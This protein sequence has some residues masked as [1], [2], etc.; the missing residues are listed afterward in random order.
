MKKWIT[1]CI[2]AMLV[3]QCLVPCA[4]TVYGTEEEI[5]NSV[6]IA[7]LSKLSVLESAGLT[8]SNEHT[9]NGEFSMKW[10]GNMS[11]T[12]I[13]IP[14]AVHDFSKYQYMEFAL[15]SSYR[16]N[17]EFMIELVSDNPDTP[18]T[19]GYSVKVT[20]DFSGRKTYSF[21][22][23]DGFVTAGSPIGWNQIDEMYFVP[24]N[25]GSADL[26]FE[27]I[28]L[29]KISHLSEE[30]EEIFMILDSGDESTY[31]SLGL[32]LTDKVYKHSDVSLTWSGNN[33]IT[34]IAF[35][36]IPSDWS[37]YKNL[38]M[39]LYV[40]T[41]SSNPLKP[42]IL[43]E[44]DTTTGADYYYT[45]V[46][47]AS[48]GW[49]TSVL[50][51]ESFT[52]SRSPV[53]W[54]NITGM[55]F[56]NTLGQTFDTST[57]LYIDRIYL[58]NRDV[59]PAEVQED[60]IVA[61]ENQKDDTDMVAM[62]KQNYPNQSHPRL[63]FDKEQLNTMKELAQY[64]AFA[65]NT[66][67]VVVAQANS[68]LDAPLEKYTNP[69]SLERVTINRVPTWAMAYLY[70]GD[71]KY[72][73]RVWAD[74][75]NICRYIDWNYG[76]SL[77][78]GD[79]ARAVA[80]MYDWLYDDWTEEQ[81]RV[82]RNALVRNAFA[83]AL[84]YMRT[85][86]GFVTQ[87]N[88]WNE[89]IN[90]GLGMAA[91]A[92]ADE[93][94]Y[95]DLCNE[96]LNRTVNALPTGLASF[97][98][99]GLSPEGVAYWTYAIYTFSQYD[100]SLFMTLG[101]DFGLSDMEGLERTGYFP[102]AAMS[103]AGNVFDFGDAEISSSKD[104]C[105][106][107]LAERYNKPELA[108]YVLDQKKYGGAFDLALYR[109]IPEGV[110]FSESM[111]LDN[112]FRGDQ[113][114]VSLRSSWDNRNALFVAFKG[115]ANYAGHNDLDQGDLVLDAMGV[116]WFRELGKED[117]NFP[118][119]WDMGPTG[120]RWQYYRKNAEG[121]NTIVIN[122]DDQ[123]M[124]YP[125]GKAPVS[126]YKTSDN[127]AYG[128]VDLT[129]VYRNHAKSVK[130]GVGLIA[131]RSKVIIRDEIKTSKASEIY[132]FY[133]T[134]ASIE[135]SQDGKSAVLE[136]EGQKLKCTLVDSGAATFG[137]MDAE[138]LPTSADP[139]VTQSPN[140]GVQKLYV[141]LTGAVDPTVTMICEPYDEDAPEIAMPNILSLNMWDAYLTDD[142]ALDSLKIDGIEVAGFTP[143]NTLYSVDTGI[144]GKITVE[145]NQDTTAEIIQAEKLGD[146]AYVVV[147]SRKTGTQTLYSVLFTE[148]TPERAFT[149]S[150]YEIKAA[151][152]SNEHSGSCAENTY[153]NDYTTAW[154]EEGE[155]WIRWDLGEAKPMDSIM[156]AYFYGN[157]RKELFDVEVSDDGMNWRQVYSGMSNGKTTALQTFTFAET[158]ARY[159]KYNAHGNNVPG[160]MWCNI[161]EVRIPEVKR[162][163]DDV[164]NH[165]A[166][167]SIMSMHTYQL[168]NGVSDTSFAPDDD[169]TRAEYVALI[170]RICGITVPTY[171][172]I[173][174]DVPADAWYSGIVE[175]AYQSGI[176]PEEMLVGGSFLPNQKIT[177]EE[178]AVVTVLA[179]E[180]VNGKVYGT[181]DFGPYAD[182]NDASGYAK[183][184]I[185]K[186]LHL[187]LI[188]GL[189]ENH[190]SP[191]D[192]ATRAE[193]AVMAKRLFTQM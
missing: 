190:F 76:A 143:G 170:S 144:C 125:Y 180:S 151:E 87:T 173:F 150:S 8:V 148:K 85:N 80:L 127:A 64:D 11:K 91:L 50:P 132:M 4:I 31:K 95:E 16:D 166:K 147:S 2:T 43:S 15:Y 46:P 139:G 9:Q 133:H 97:A 49:Q 7:D 20:T 118:G 113:E 26:Y 34:D 121:Q 155:Q 124:Q 134:D 179:Y 116:R 98:P 145:T 44:N 68:T 104:A 73:D 79:Y 164:Q 107:W 35:H 152:A 96:I 82:M 188:K 59:S 158:N 41:P 111:S 163:F 185:Q 122:P 112:L 181:F 84:S 128:I 183:P 83:P 81:R 156:V 39:E 177:R 27:E 89:V 140:V 99:D 109:G 175:A 161:S 184:Y 130:R 114:M 21:E 40:K 165:W 123:P 169:I 10:S 69:S 126:V 106:F 90:S 33:I 110:S 55:Q 171:E 117:Y 14:L 94:G 154:A 52:K 53:G 65:K 187:R 32:P 178:M 157:N 47:I 17:T 192:Y 182:C 119:M 74:I 38:V 101:T 86:T 13:K 67:S 159:I 77:E 176:I 103:T 131:N 92:L 36:N 37:V 193:A 78:V 54:Q 58:T 24:L 3:L 108:A 72:K 60:Y 57:V 88:N 48:T 172:G 62:L 6:T 189:T 22:L 120:G 61:A 191:Y 25:S 100:K 63:L 141:H 51:L 138:P 146:T 45:S 160:S 135:I 93:P 71:I 168:L 56:W 29:E 167:D 1:Y 102:I 129:D 115:G 136:L 5:P 137:K 186:G 12:R 18:V 162:V 153:D 142:A 70:T 23:G 42:V 149:V 19:D 30:K 28:K 174:R 66:L 105:F 75:E